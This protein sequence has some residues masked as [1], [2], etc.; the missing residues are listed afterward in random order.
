MLVCME[1][2]TDLL[3]VFFWVD[4]KNSTCSTT[5][6]QVTWVNNR[7]LQYTGR[8]LSEHLGPGWLSHM[9]PDDQTVCHKAWENAFEQGNGFAGEYRL[10]RFD[11]VYRFFLWRI[12]PLRDLKG[13]IIHW[14]GKVIYFYFLF[15]CALV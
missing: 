12:V 13:R 6:G 9:H 3:L 1:C 4:Y 11:G 14:F 5:T 8:S 15:V 7:I 2:E 10:R